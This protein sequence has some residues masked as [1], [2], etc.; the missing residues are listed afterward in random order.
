MN[1]DSEQRQRRTRS[2]KIR[3]TDAEH[4][5]LVERCG[6]HALAAWLRDLGLGQHVQR[7]HRVPEA[8]PA[9]LRG[10]AAIGNNLN[11]VARRVNSGQWSAADRLTVLAELRAI[12]DELHELR[13]DHAG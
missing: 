8:D 10:L 2:I 9:L 7:R 11:Q 1:D 3:M 5:A 6:Q 4:A 12:H 13:R